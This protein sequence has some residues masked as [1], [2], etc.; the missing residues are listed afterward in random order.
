MQHTD[1]GKPPLMIK[2]D[3]GI[4]VKGEVGCW[5]N[6]TA[7]EMGGPNFDGGT[8]GSDQARGLRRMGTGSGPRW[9]E[10]EC[11]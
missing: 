1:T 11:E 8:I 6:A 9:T 7:D 10:C 2:S 4:P 3:E 5:G